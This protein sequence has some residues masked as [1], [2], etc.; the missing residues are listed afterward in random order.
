V[1]QR[2]DAAAGRCVDG[3]AGGGRI[4]AEL[5]LAVLNM[6]LEP[7]R[8]DTVILFGLNRGHE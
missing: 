2:A 1:H 3:W 8:R 6:A 5:V 4:T 7:R